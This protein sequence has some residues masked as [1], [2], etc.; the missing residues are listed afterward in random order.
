MVSPEKQGQRRSDAADAAA[1]KR[2]RI[3]PRALMISMAV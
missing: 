1:Q 3:A 2:P